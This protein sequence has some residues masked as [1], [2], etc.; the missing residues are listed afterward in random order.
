MKYKLYKNIP[1]F[2]AI[3]DIAGRYNELLKLVSKIPKNIPII[4]LGDVTCRGPHSCEV[5]NYLIEK[6]I[7]VL[8]SNHGYMFCDFLDGIKIEYRMRF[9]YWGGIQTLESYGVKVDENFKKI[10]NLL[11]HRMITPNKDIYDYNNYL[12]LEAKKRVPKKHIDFLKNLPLFIETDSVILSHAPI[13]K[14][15]LHKNPF[16]IV[17]YRGDACRMEKIQIHGHTPAM[18]I[19][20]KDDKGIYGYNIDTSMRNKLTAIHWPSKLIYQVNYEK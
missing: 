19:E 13:Y 18:E 20:L 6:N 5:I 4:S 7:F 12:Y 11:K 17:S 10:T 9:L 15:F 16:K 14:N 1:E 2:V 8:Q 3:G